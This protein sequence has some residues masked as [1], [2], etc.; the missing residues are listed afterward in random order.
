M[1]RTPFGAEL[2]REQRMAV[3][4]VTGHA[5]RLLSGLGRPV[6]EHA[7]AELHAIA[8]DPVVYGIALGNVLAAIERG[9]WDHLQP[10]ADLYRAAGADAEV[11]DRQR[12]WRLSRPWPI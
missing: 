1:K 7:V 12:A 11:A 5:E 9:G 3:A 10:M 2:S 6:D 8:T 4:A